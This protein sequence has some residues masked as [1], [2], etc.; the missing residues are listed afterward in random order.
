ME[1]ATGGNI[2]PPVGH[3]PGAMP[4]VRVVNVFAES[5]PLAGTEPE[6]CSAW[7]CPTCGKTYDQGPGVCPHDGRAL[8]A[9][10]PSF[11]LG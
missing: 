10:S 7:Q 5:I 11:W 3:R 8:Q 9:L 1:P 4:S 2:Q 6:D